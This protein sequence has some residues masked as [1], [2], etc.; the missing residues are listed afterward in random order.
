MKTVEEKAQAYD[1]AIERA[2]KLKENPQSVFN[3]YSPK[4]GDTICDYIF[5]ELKELGDEKIRKA[6]VELVKCNERS[7]YTLLNNVSTSS[8]LAWLEKQGGQKVSVVE[9][10]AK[11]WYVSKVDGKIYNAKFMEKTPT[12]QA[13]KLEIEKAAM[14]ATG[15]IEQEEWFIKGAEWSDKNPSYISSEKQGEQKPTLRE[16]YKNIANSEW[17]K[18]TYEGM[19]I[20]D[21][22]EVDNV[23]NIEP[24]F[25]VG[26]WIVNRLG[27]IWH[28]DSFDTKNYQVT[29]NK[30]EH[31]YFPIN[32]QDRM[33]IWT[34]AD[35]KDG[36]ILVG[37]IDGDDYI[38]IFKQIKDG[39]IETYGH[40][41]DTVDRFCVPSQLFCRD[42]KGTFYPATKVQRDLLFQKMKEAGY[43][44]DSERKELKIVDWSKHIK[45]NPNTPSIIKEKPVWSEKDE[46]NLNDAILFIE[47][48]TYSLDK[49][50]LINWLKSLKPQNTWKPSDEQMVVL[51]LAS[52]YERVFTPKQIDILIDL[53]EQLK[54]LKGE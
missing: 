14:S 16:R 21:D 1:E 30:G 22:E 45:Y 36:D 19:S 13:R 50:N 26:D 39:W 32:I 38:L 23:N 43:E 40:Y 49:D 31:N 12:N 46:R 44:W 53:K 3:E 17:F 25:K 47:T 7:G 15:I 35:A 20:S 54:K 4:E 37:K 52:K 9:F 28:I 24:K 29:T 11:D 33:H 10:N 48:G 6:L 5:P 27:N 34:I 41:Y 42:Y 8:M 18:K 2:K 51:E